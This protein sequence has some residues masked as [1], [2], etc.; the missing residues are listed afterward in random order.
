MPVSRND[1]RKTKAYRKEQKQEKD[2]VNQKRGHGVKRS[3][4]VPEEE[5]ER[6]V[7]YYKQPL[8]ILQAT[9]TWQ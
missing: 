8:P 3:N 7:L 9:P 2:R 6:E 5:N 1:S 4:G